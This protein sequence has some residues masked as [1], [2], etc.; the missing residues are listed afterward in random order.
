VNET[1]ATLTQRPRSISDAEWT[2]GLRASRIGAFR[3]IFLSRQVF[4]GLP[5]MFLGAF[6]YQ[7]YSAGGDVLL[8]LN[9]TVR[10][11]IF[12]GFAFFLLFAGIAGAL[13]WRGKRQL[14]LRTPIDE[15]HDSIT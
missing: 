5:A 11:G 3:Y 10:S 15:R 9:G 13:D 1:K 8:A 12:I 14:V 2:E 4:I 6:C 7:L